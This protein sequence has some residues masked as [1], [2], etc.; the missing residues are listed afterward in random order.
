M[1]IIF[2]MRRPE[3]FARSNDRLDKSCAA[4]KLQVSKPGMPFVVGATE[5][6][7]PFHASTGLW[8]KAE[9]AKKC[10]LSEQSRL[11]FGDGAKPIG[12]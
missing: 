8:R 11:I 3:L 4:L 7:F 9:V 6:H 5:F 10:S 12:N 2:H 1:P